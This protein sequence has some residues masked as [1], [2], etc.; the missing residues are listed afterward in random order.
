MGATIQT[1]RETALKKSGQASR[2]KKALKV[3][4]I[5]WQTS[6]KKERGL[7]CTGKVSVNGRKGLEH[8]MQGQNKSRRDE[9]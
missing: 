8:G 6:G 9:S 2:E 7:P 5:P 3:G 4:G 1:T